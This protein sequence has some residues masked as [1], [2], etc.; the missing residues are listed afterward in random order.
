MKDRINPAYQSPK[1]CTSITMGC[2]EEVRDG[3]VKEGGKVK[4]RVGR[5]VLHMGHKR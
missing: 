2:I 4:R 3:E 1:V 5:G